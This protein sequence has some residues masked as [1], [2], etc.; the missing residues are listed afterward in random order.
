ME[1]IC[2]CQEQDQKKRLGGLSVGKKG[3]LLWS[4]YREANHACLP[5]QAGKKQNNK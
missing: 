1:W 3:G 5:L 4:P 2:V